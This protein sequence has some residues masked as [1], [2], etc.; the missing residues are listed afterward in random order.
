MNARLL[1]IDI[2]L[3]MKDISRLCIEC[4]T[5]DASFPLIPDCQSCASMLS[6]DEY[7]FWNSS[8]NLEIE[9][10]YILDNKLQQSIQPLRYLF[11]LIT[12]G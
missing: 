1:S 10:D 5:I 8:C 2:L 11:N 12:L 3:L 6:E 9:E 7:N 4:R